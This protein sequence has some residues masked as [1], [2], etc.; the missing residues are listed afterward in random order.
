MSDANYT[1]FVNLFPK[2]R[3]EAAVPNV[4]PSTAATDAAGLKIASYIVL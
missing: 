2:N 1:A 4:F 3:A